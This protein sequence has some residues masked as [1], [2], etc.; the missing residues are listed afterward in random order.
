MPQNKHC[1]FRFR[2]KAIRS[3][4]GPVEVITP[5]E[6][7]VDGVALTK[8]ADGV[9]EGPLLIPPLPLLFVELQPPI[10]DVGEG[11]ARELLDDEVPLL[12][13]LLRDARLVALA[14]MRRFKSSLSS[15]FSGE[16][17][18]S[19]QPTSRPTNKCRVDTPSER[20]EI[21]DRWFNNCEPSPIATDSWRK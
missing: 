3:L 16:T 6:G 5:F 4:S 9:S 8:R 13:L 2:F 17:Y 14:F 12:L 10:P 15:D 1:R 20:E 18:L 19:K 7:V 21:E 11:E